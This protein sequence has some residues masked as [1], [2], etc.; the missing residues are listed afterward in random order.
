MLYGILKRAHVR[1]Y[2]NF[3]SYRY[4]R[5]RHGGRSRE[6]WTT[7]FKTGACLTRLKGNDGVPA[8]CCTGGHV[9]HACLVEMP[10]VTTSALCAV[11]CNGI[12]RELL[13]AVYVID[14][15]SC[16]ITRMRESCAAEIQQP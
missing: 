13:L 12:T 9:R 15:R 16:I 11:S 8:I 2:S 6:N 3:I 14:K 5:N 10:L 7:G 4:E 1:R